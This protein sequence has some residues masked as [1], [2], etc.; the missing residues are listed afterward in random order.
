MDVFIGMS[1]VDFLCVKYR[2][3]NAKLY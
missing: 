3:L 1:E 2:G